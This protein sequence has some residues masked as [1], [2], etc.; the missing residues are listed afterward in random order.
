M[1]SRVRN[2]LLLVGTMV[3][4]VCLSGCA[5]AGPGV[6]ASAGPVRDVTSEFNTV[7]GD[8][9][10]LEQSF[11]E[12]LAAAQAVLESTRGEELRNPKVLEELRSQVKAAEGATV[13][14]PAIA[15]EAGAVAGQVA[16]LR[17]QHARLQVQYE[18]L[19]AAVDTVATEKT[20][21]M[22]QVVSAMKSYSIKAIDG[23]GN[24]QKITVRIGSWI[25]GSDT[26]LVEMGW[27]GVGGEGEMPL[28]GTYSRQ[29]AGLTDATFTQKDA[30][31]VFGTMSIENLTPDFDAENFNGGAAWVSLKL[32]VPFDGAFTSWR[33]L[34]WECGE[35][36]QAVQYNDGVDTSVMYGNQLAKANMTSDE[37]GPVPFVI[38]VDTVFSPK[39]RKGDPV[40]VDTRFV[41]SSAP[42]IKVTGD[43][44]FRIKKTW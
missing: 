11:A 40:L 34:S 24:R 25:K 31:Y 29:S 2:A 15:S 39:H 20:A 37:W 21:K 10:K 16:D 8:I 7:R 19:Q 14:I 28:T 43:T 9:A 36:V 42:F 33:D 22:Q 5:S 3:V 44:E 30:A 23:N 38:G 18:D 32:L 6:A 17:A 41:L 13:S 26:E 4:V 12:E 1:G 35:V 27:Q